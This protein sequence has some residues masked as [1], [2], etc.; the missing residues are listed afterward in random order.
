M[1]RNIRSHA[2]SME[3]TC[4]QIDADAW[5]QLEIVHPSYAS[6]TIRK[7]HSADAVHVHDC[8]WPSS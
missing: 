5:C 8:G 1:K 2:M 3:L 6:K 4:R 7:G